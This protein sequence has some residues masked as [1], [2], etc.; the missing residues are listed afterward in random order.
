MRRRALRPSFVVTFALGAAAIASGCSSKD[1]GNGSIGD[2]SIGDGSVGDSSIGDAGCPAE[3][4]TNGSPCDPSSPPCYY[5]A[6]TCWCSPLVGM[7]TCTQ[8][9]WNVYSPLCNPPAPPCDAGPDVDDAAPDV[10]DG[11][12]AVHDGGS[13]GEGQDG[14]HD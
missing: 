11:G 7:A 1:S 9:G 8:Q 13:D 6:G 12:S 10:Y 3:L 5:E 2:G 4:P 14:G